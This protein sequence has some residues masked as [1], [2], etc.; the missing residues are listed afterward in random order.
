MCSYILYLPISQLL[1]K[2][3]YLTAFNP[4]K[5]DHW[6]WGLWQNCTHVVLLVHPFTYFLVNRYA[7]HWQSFITCFIQGFSIFCCC[8]MINS[9]DATPT[10]KTD[11]LINSWHF[12]LLQN[13]KAISD[14]SRMIFNTYRAKYIDSSSKLYLNNSQRTVYCIWSILLNNRW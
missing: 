11:L 12:V 2:W 10:T 1:D 4:C 7:T 5:S 8:Y 3:L 13:T 14:S 9:K 6:Q